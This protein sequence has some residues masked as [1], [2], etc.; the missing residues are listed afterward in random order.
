MNASFEF[1]NYSNA[2]QL[3]TFLMN[4]CWS[5]WMFQVLKLCS[6]NLDEEYEFVKQWNVRA[7]KGNS[8]RVSGRQSQGT[9]T[10]PFLEVLS[11]WWLFYIS[12][13]S[14]QQGSQTPEV[15]LLNC[16]VHIALFQEQTGST[17]F[18]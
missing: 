13:V 4:E 18:M 9:I 14:V 15:T 17:E 12:F 7:Y 5:E 3:K 11:K 1:F 8:T 2:V 6:K 16:I 10:I